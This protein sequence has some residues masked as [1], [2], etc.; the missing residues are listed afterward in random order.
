MTY[1][2]FVASAAYR[3]K[4]SGSH[5]DVVIINEDDAR[6]IVI[7]AASGLNSGENFE[8]LAVEEV[9]EAGANEIV[10]GRHDGSISVPAFWTP[11]WNDSAPTR[12]NFIGRRFII[13]ERVASERPGSGVVLN[14]YTGA[15]LRSLNSAVGAR[16]LRTF[17]LSFVFLTRYSGEE[18]AAK[19]ASGG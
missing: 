16:G 17:D 9:G 5:I 18:W 6:D 3:E 7:G 1:Q 19:V 8:A 11:A 13:L 4:F 2:E 10:Q 14:A 15:T 12:Q